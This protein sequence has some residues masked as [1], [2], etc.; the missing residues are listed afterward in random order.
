MTGGGSGAGALIGGLA[1]GGSGA[2]I[3]AG[4]GA[5]AGVTTAA[6]TGKRQVAF[7]AESLLSFKTSQPF[8]VQPLS[9]Q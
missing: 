5:A 6:I 3:G 7:P 9:Y 4:A 2:L 1:A 8:N